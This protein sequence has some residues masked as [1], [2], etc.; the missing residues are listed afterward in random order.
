MVRSKEVNVRFGA[1]RSGRYI[2]S[3][4]LVCFVK[5][6]VVPHTVTYDITGTLVAMHMPKMRVRKTVN[7]GIGIAAVPYNARSY[8]V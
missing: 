7:E 3:M 2:S 1:N 8:I 5:I 6:R 4:I